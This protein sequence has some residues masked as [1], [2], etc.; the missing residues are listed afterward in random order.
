MGSYNM[1][2]RTQEETLYNII[3]LDRV[4]ASDMYNLFIDGMGPYATLY[5]PKGMSKNEA[6]RRWFNELPM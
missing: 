5:I 6:Y 1:T 3:R 2:T 4:G